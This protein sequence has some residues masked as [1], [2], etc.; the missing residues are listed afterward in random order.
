MGTA[1]DGAFHTTRWSVVRS[2]SATRPDAARA[3]LSE[4]CETYWRPVYAYARSRGLAPED[5]AD[6][7]QALFARLIENRQL[8]GVDAERGS[9]RSW[10][11]A[12]LENQWNNE[13]ARAATLK[14]GGAHAIASLDVDEAERNAATA[15]D[16]DPA[17]AFDRA[18]VRT[19]LTA[20]LDELAAE[21][22]RRD[23]TRLFDALRPTL[24]GSGSPRTLAELAQ[25]LGTTEG[26]LKVAA[27]RLRRAFRE[28]LRRRV[29]ETVSRAEDID[30]ELEELWRAAGT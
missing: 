30:G 4:L 18:W 1:A 13:R 23:R 26:A 16:E 11:R 20:A 27:H 22:A 10:L 6:L 12:A 29:A 15:R 24:D 9:F 19:V 2:A 7:T 5:A 3:A 8:A 14:R 25:E 17:R 21:Y 28:A